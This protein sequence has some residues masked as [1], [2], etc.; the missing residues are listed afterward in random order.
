MYDW[1][2]ENGMPIPTIRRATRRASQTTD[3]LR[4]AQTTGHLPV[5]GNLPAKGTLVRNTQ[6]L[7]PPSRVLRNTESLRNKRKVP[8]WVIIFS[9]LAISVVSVRVTWFFVAHQS[10]ESLVFMPEV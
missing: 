4:L 9:I 8:M 10:L 2:D 1:M 7:I 3:P 6:Q 5:T